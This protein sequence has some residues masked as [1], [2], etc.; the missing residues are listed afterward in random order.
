MRFAVRQARV[1]RG[2]GWQPADPHRG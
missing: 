2:R 1:T